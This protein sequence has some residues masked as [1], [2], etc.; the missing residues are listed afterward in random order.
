VMDNASLIVDSRNITAGLVPTKAQ[1]VSL[2]AYRL[3]ADAMTS[4]ARHA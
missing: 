2:A 1:V 4:A 3:P